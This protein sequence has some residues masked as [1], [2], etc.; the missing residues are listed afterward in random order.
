MKLMYNLIDKVV[1]KVLGIVTMITINGLLLTGLK[2]E[3]LVHNMARDVLYN[4]Y[5]GPSDMTMEAYQQGCRYISA[6][7]TI[8]SLVVLILAALILWGQII[9]IDGSIKEYKE[10]KNTEII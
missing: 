9:D 5:I 1:M 8:A 10:L 4:M 7:C 6:G 3:G 2:Q